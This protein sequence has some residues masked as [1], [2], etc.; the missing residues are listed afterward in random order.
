VKADKLISLNIYCY[1]YRDRDLFDGI[2]ATMVEAGSLK[3]VDGE[4]HVN[5]RMYTDFMLK[6]LDDEKKQV[7]D[8]DSA[9]SYWVIADVFFSTRNNFI[10]QL[11][12]KYLCEED[13][14]FTELRR[15]FKVVS[16]RF[17]EI[18]ERYVRASEL[19][20]DLEPKKSDLKVKKKVAKRKPE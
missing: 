1:D 16:P 6:L 13:A 7:Q 2:L 19:R 8:K 10:Y 20:L 9:F 14:D 18:A 17:R 15:Q 4:I 3:V 11:R 5:V 12:H